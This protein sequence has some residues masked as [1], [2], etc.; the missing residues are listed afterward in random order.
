LIVCSLVIVSFFSSCLSDG[1]NWAINSRSRP[2][3]SL[4]RLKERISLAPALVE[5]AQGWVSL[6]CSS[7]TPS[8]CT[9]SGPSSISIS[10][11]DTKNFT[12]QLSCAANYVYISWIPIPGVTIAYQWNG[13]NPIITLSASSAA[14]GT[15]TFQTEWCD[16]NGQH[17]QYDTQIAVSVPCGGSVCSGQACQNGACVTPSYPCQYSPTSPCSATT[18]GATSFPADGQSHTFTI[19]LTSCTAT[20]IAFSST[21]T[22]TPQWVSNGLQ[23]TVHDNTKGD[24]GSVTVNFCDENNYHVQAVVPF[25]FT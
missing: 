21:V 2:A 12:I 7:S 17:A 9:G 3:E 6:S 22:I 11:G 25:N 5:E 15:G 8:P 18:T 14:S 10:P 13:T 23:V 4:Q 16:G 1:N 24:S 19:A 20:Y